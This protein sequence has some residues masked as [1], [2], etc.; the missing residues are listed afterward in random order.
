M[1]KITINAQRS[2][3]SADDVKNIVLPHYT[4]GNKISCK[5]HSAGTN[6]E[7]LVKADKNEYILRIYRSN[8]RTVDEVESEIQLLK[9]LQKSGVL[10]AAPVAK[11]D[12]SYITIL[13]CAEG[14]RPVVMFEKVAGKQAV[15][16]EDKSRICGRLTAQLHQQ[17]AQ[18]KP[19]KRFDYNFQQLVDEPLALLKTFMTDSP[20]EYKYMANLAKKQKAKIS[21]LLS[22]ESDVYGICHSKLCADEIFFDAQ[23]NPIIC[24]F[25]DFGN[26]WFAYDISVFL[27]RNKNLSVWTKEEKAKTDKIWQAFLAGYNEIKPLSDNEM[28]SI[29]AF[30]PL[31]LIY[32]IASGI[33]KMPYSGYGLDHEGFVWYVD[34]LKKWGRTYKELSKESLPSQFKTNKE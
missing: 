7:Y 26:G 18:L 11:T 30:A 17:T 27:W 29:L 33:E 19:L 14:D 5:Y 23:N 6:D 22:G 1:K 25:D 32:A 31:R 10:V 9:H 4:L 24:N 16:D 20:K 12:G 21:A 8:R 15:I 13:D 3:F 34:K 2:I 28:K